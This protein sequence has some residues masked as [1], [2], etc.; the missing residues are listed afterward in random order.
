[1]NCN[2]EKGCES[3]H[4]HRFD[5]S[6]NQLHNVIVWMHQAKVFCRKFRVR[7]SNVNYQ[8]PRMP[9]FLFFSSGVACVFAACS[10]AASRDVGGLQKQS[11]LKRDFPGCQKLIL[12]FLCVTSETTHDGQTVFWRDDGVSF[13]PT[14]QHLY[15]NPIP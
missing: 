15:A 7:R 12:M 9:S 11:G 5:R 4:G 14:T 13:E 10:G 6:G 2:G 1:M 8:C 3:T